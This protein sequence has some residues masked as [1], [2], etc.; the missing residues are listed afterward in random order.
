[1][2]EVAVSCRVS[3]FTDSPRAGTTSSVA[4][5]ET[6]R[7]AG[8]TMAEA[9]PAALRARCSANTEP[10]TAT[11]IQGN[12][13]TRGERLP[14]IHREVPKRLGSIPASISAFTVIRGRGCQ[15]LETSRR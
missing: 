3:S 9:S 1:M 4:V 8:K 15:I 10:R 11:N 6:M 2:G 5:P 13:S 12:T 7:L 14:A